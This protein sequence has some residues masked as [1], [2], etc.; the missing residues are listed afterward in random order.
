MHLLTPAQCRAARALLSWGQPELASRCGTHVQTISNF[1]KESGSPTRTTIDKIAAAFKGAGIE[2]LPNNGVALREDN[3]FQ[4]SG[5]EG[6]RLFM[7]D[8][9]ATAL[10]TGGEIVLFNA[11][12]AYWYKW[13]GEEWFG[14]HA[15]RMKMLGDKINFKITSRQG[16]T[17][18]ISKEFAEYRWFPEDLYDDRALYSYGDKIAFVNF[19]EDQVSVTVFRHE[20]FANAFRVLFNI[21]WDNVAIIPE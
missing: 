20:S 9:Y 11:Y 8:L 6:L 10:E 21:A 15:R 19:S 5:A 1:E 2:F 16:D 18:F 4:Y 7:D 14:E 17:M 12:P 13:L 3:V